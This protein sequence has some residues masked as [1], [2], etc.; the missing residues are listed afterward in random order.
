MQIRHSERN[1]KRSSRESRKEDENNPET[2]RIVEQKQ[3]GE[4]FTSV[5]RHHFLHGIQFYEFWLF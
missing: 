4:L 5:I 3:Y 1:A 2:Q